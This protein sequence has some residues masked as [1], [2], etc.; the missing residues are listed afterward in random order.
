MESSIKGIEIRKVMMQ[1]LWRDSEINLYNI[2]KAVVCTELC[3]GSLGHLRLHGLCCPLWCR[4]TNL[5]QQVIHLETK[6]L[7]LFVP[8]RQGFPCYT[9]EGQRT[10]F[11]IIPYIHS[12]CEV[13]DEHSSIHFQKSI[14]KILANKL[15]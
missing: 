6:G 13:K 14:P 9:K 4:L 12:K 7:D 10:Q 3:K 2:V 15:N 5:F 1:M 11:N 8:R